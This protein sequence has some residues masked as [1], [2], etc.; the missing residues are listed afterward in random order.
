M[1]NGLAHPSLETGMARY[2]LC[3]LY[4]TDV[5]KTSHARGPHVGARAKMF[6]PQGVCGDGTLVYFVTFPLLFA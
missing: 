5:G 3:T 1:K 6:Y 4:T 2:I